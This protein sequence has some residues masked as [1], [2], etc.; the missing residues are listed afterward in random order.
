MRITYTAKR[1][2]ISGHT[3]TTD[4]TLDLAPRSVQ[5]QTRNHRER[6]VALDQV[7]VE[8]NL[9]AIATYWSVDAGSMSSADADQW[10][11]FFA[12]VAGGE[13]FQFDPYGLGSADDPR[14]AIMESEQF[15]RRPIQTVA[16]LKFSFPTFR[17]REV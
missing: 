4:Y 7:S 10:E 12:S 5:K 6:T 15:D 13:S 8:T 11:E 9:A 2:L 17:I 1:A 3:A 14:A 16:G